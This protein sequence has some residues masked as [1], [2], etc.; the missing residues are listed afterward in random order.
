MDLFLV[1][2][3]AGITLVLVARQLLPHLRLSRLRAALSGRTPKDLRAAAV[4]G[5]KLAGK[6]LF[7]ADLRGVDLTDATLDKAM[8][9]G[10]RFDEATMV[11]ASAK[12]THLAHAKL[13]STDLTAADLSFDRHFPDDT[14]TANYA[15]LSHATID[16]ANLSRGRF[17]YAQFNN[18]SLQGTDLS[19]AT[20][21]GAGF[22][23]ADLR[24][25]DLRFAD[26]SRSRLEEADLRGANL[27][28]ANL[29]GANLE[30]ARIDEKTIWRGTRYN[31]RTRWFDGTR[32]RAPLSE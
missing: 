9:E 27:S 4:G 7:D 31:Q 12:N 2:L 21:V 22:Q 16:Q 18:S 32:Q 8:L 25:A 19:R 23:A 14:I 30:G 26:L 5:N 13:R 17:S 20:L 29:S 15:Q 3:A 11:R 1:G 28:F 6:Y 10:G 24:G